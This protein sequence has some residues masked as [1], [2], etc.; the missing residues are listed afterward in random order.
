MTSEFTIAVHALVFLDS[1]GG[2]VSSETLAENIC[3]N[4]A[5]VRKVMALLKK[6]GLVYTQ[7]GAVG[8]YRFAG[9]AGKVTLRDV[10]KAVDA[11]FVSSAWRS[12]SLDKP[13]LIASGMAGA[14]DELYSRLDAMCREKLGE[15]NLAMLENRLLGAQGNVA[16]SPCGFSAD[17]TMMNQ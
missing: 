16:G 15:I 14:M 8:G 13:C 6:A 7:E 17:K 2:T 11:V 1:R 9:D 3:T 12:G 10:A 4:P 5:R